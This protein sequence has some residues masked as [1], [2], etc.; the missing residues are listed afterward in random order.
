MTELAFVRHA[1]T[2][3]NAR[4]LIQGSTD[5]PLN[6]AGI[7]EVRGWSLPARFASHDLLSSPLG[8]AVETA[9]LLAGRAPG[10]DPRLREMCWGSW[11]GRTLK[12]LR[13][14]IGNLMIAW[15]ARG[16]DFH[17]P[18][19]E[20]PRDVQA[21]MVPLLS[22][23]AAAGRPTLAVTHRGVIRAIQALAT[24]WNMESRAEVRADDH[25]VQLFNLDDQGRPHIR[26]LNI[27]MKK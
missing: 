2:D 15:E 27:S 4:G 16:L 5:I 26:E 19:G 9:E 18:G 24:G 20:S 14:E 1:T 8:R 22:E 25:G 21:R 12:G 23:L 7:A 6:R 13:D 10:I 17:G 11:E 3:W